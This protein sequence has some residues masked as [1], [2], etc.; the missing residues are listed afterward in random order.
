LSLITDPES[1][2]AYAVTLSVLGRKKSGNKQRTIA[3]TK[4]EFWSDC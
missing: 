2:V 4:T 1:V 3:I